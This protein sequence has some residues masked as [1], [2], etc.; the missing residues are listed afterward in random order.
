MTST[1][2][3]RGLALAGR[4]ERTHPHETVRAGLDAERAERV[5][6]VDLECRGLDARFLR[7]RRVHHGHRILVLLG[8]PQVHAQEHLREVGGI[9]SP[10]TRA[11]RD[12]GRALVVLAVQERL[13]LELADDVLELGELVAGLFG[14]VLVVHLVGQ[15]DHDFE[16]V[17]AA[18]DVADACELG[19]TV[20]ERARH[21]LRLVGVVPQIR[22]AGLFTETG[23][24]GGERIDVDHRLDVGERGAQRL[25]IG[26]QIEI[27]HD[28]PD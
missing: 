1:A 2:A 5:G 7:V 17:E 13:H 14:G 28:S 10:G 18:L 27:K 22:R 21:L 26:G 16:V 25:N 23:D 11:D 3:K 19:L 4:V 6:R 9:H 8:P 20:T 15:L 24:L 12:D